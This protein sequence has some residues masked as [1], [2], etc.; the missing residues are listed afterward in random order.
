MSTFR[1][2][3]RKENSDLKETSKKQVVELRDLKEK[4]EKD[5]KIYEYNLESLRTRLTKANYEL[6]NLEEKLLGIFTKGQIAKLK[7]GIKRTKWTEEDIT[8]AIT[9]YATSAKLYKLLHRKQFPL[10]AV[11]TLQA[12]GQKVHITPGLLGPVFKLLSASTH[13]T[14]IDKICVLSFDE[15]KIR[16]SYCYDKTSDTTLAPANYVQVAMIRGQ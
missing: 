14:E 15:A 4:T 1:D 16:K 8:Q 7:A 12:W 3:L 5:F 9:L 11:R 2:R 10:P 6:T 13:M